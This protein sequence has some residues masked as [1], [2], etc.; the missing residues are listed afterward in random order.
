MYTINNKYF[1]SPDVILAEMDGEGVFLN[2]K[3]EKYY[4]LN[5]TGMDIFKLLI[6]DSDKNEIVFQLLEKYN[7]DEKILQE[8]IV[9][10]VNEL[11]DANIIIEGPSS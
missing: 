9:R 2:I 10:L 6:N 4:S 3:T 1:E 7:V 8:D 11:V 5:K